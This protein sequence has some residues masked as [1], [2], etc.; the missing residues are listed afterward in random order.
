MASTGL[1]GI[2]PYQQGVNLDISSKA[3]NSYMQLQQKEAAKSDAIDKFYKDWEKSINPVGLSGQE[4]GVFTKKLNDAKEYGIK[5]KEFINQPSRDGYEANSGMTARY[6]DLQTYIEGA[7]QATAS[8]KA[9]KTKLD[10]ATSEGKIYT[11]NAL[12]VLRKAMLPYGE[13]YEEPSLTGIKIY[14]PHN[15]KKFEG[16]IMAGLKLKEVTDLSPIRGDKGEDTGYSKKITKLVSDNDTLRSMG[17][18]AEV[19]YHTNE[20]TK[21]QMNTLFQDID[22]VNKLTP[23]YSRVYSYQDP[24]TGQMIMPTIQSPADFTKAY[25]LAK[26][27]NDTITSEENVLNDLGIFKKWKRQHDIEVADRRVSDSAFLK[28]LN[29][30]GSGEILSNS[31]SNYSTNK[32]FADNSS[33]TVMNFPQ[34]LYND[35]RKTVEVPKSIEDKAFKDAGLPYDTKSVPV[36]PVYGKNAKGQVFYAYPVI[37]DNGNKVANKYDWN[38][39]VPITDAIKNKLINTDVGSERSVNI[40]KAAIPFIMQ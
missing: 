1:L 35:Y 26:R 19:E 37:D 30:Q 4:L 39:A 11:D 20:G 5:N 12:E 9:F 34:D 18:N 36:L 23:L 25:A 22:L 13:G 17:N 15:E 2:N 28:Q 24:A 27:P 40:K 29:I 32:P 16:N 38:N 21:Q 7:K 31:L 6:K 10:E 33:L 14:T 3:A 8:R